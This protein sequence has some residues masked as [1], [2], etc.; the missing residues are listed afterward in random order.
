MSYQRKQGDRMKQE[1]NL[2]AKYARKFNLAHTFEDRRRAQ[3]K[4]K[5]KHR[6]KMYE[7]G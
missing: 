2:V 6:G 4:G 3:K 7:N 5:V 1:N